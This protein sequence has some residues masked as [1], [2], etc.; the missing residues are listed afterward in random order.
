[1]ATPPSTTRNTSAITSTDKPR[2][3]EKKRGAGLASRLQAALLALVLASVACVADPTAEHPAFP[4]A[5]GYGQ[6]A[7]GWRGGEVVKIVNTDDSGP[8]S[9]RHCLETRTEP[10]V[11]IVEVS[12][13]IA[14]HSGIRIQPNVYLAGKTA[15]GDGLQIRLSDR[16]EGSAP[17]IVKNSHDVLIRNLKS[18]PG[19]GGTPSSSI[20]AILLENA[21]RVM[22]DRLSLMFA[23]DQVFSVRSENGSARD[24]TLQRSIVAYGLDRSNHPKGRH[25]KGALICSQNDTAP[26]NGDRCGFITLWGNLF[27]HNNDRNPDLKASSE[28]PLQLVNNVFYNARSQFGEFYDFSGSLQVDYIGNLVLYG[29]NTIRSR[30]PYPVELLDFTEEFDVI[31]Y[32]RDNI[33]EHHRGSSDLPDAEIVP[34][35]ARHQLVEQPLSLDAMPLPILPVEEVFGAVAGMVGDRLPEGRRALDPIDRQVVADLE[36][37]SGRIIDDPS[38]IGGYPVLAGGVMPPDRDGDGMSDDWERRH[39][40]LDPDRFDAWEDRDRDGW[41]NLEEYL[42]ALAGDPAPGTGDGARP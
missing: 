13:T 8:G 11:C 1:M 17:L 20:S 2:P 12:G 4:D 6:T 39:E 37:R 40:G 24:I 3:A 7:T 26:E 22:L 35:L 19:P 10:R 36:R 34:P 42:S 33:G 25:S 14:L 29:P 30:P 5:I 9:L 16:S 32:V 38:D 41:A 21:E 23:S 18:R 15:P 27:A 28:M 31:A